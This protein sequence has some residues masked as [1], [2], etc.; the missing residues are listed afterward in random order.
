M[1]L[2]I[3]KSRFYGFGM[4]NIKKNIYV[5]VSLPYL[6]QASMIV[7][8]AKTFEKMSEFSLD[9]SLSLGDVFSFEIEGLG[10]KEFLFDFLCDG[11]KVEF[12]Y[13]TGFLKDSEGTVHY[14]FQKDVNPKG[15]ENDKPLCIPMDD[16]VIYST[17]VRG[18]SMG[19]KSIKKYKGTFKALALKADYFKSFSVNALELMPVYEFEGE[20]NYWGFGKANHFAINRKYSYSGNPSFEFK[21]MVQTLHSK[22]IEV[23]LILQFENNDT[24]YIC[25]VAKFYVENYHI[26]GF[27]FICSYTDYES[28]KNNPFLKDTKLFFENAKTSDFGRAKGRRKNIGTCSDEFLNNARRFLKGDED[29]VPFLSFA[30]R[31]NSSC[32]IPV[33][34]IS[35]FRSFTLYDTVSFNKK[36]NEA[37]NEE[38]LDGTNYNYSWNCGEEGEPLKKKTLALRLRQVRNAALITYLCQGIPRINGGDEVLNSN[39]GNN[40]PYCQDNEIGWITWNNKKYAKDYSLFLQNL[41]RFRNRHKILHQNKELMMFDYMSCKIPDVSFHS[42]KAFALDQ[43]PSSREF[44]VMY[45]GDYSKQYGKEKEDHIIVFYNM[46]WEERS[47]EIPEFKRKIDWFLLYSSDKTTDDSF[48][49]SKAVPVREKVYKLPGRTVTVLIGRD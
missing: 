26:D 2:K 48:D 34:F 5:G 47:F 39:F 38:N 27:R 45:C 15:F 7:Y 8:D 13:A 32:S 43:T 44:G 19:D 4:K 16:N 12:P 9:E 6:K 29:I 17:H 10:E 22:G 35:D 42:E 30:V 40:N 28:I 3:I 31:E 24:S 25:E 46:H 33:R 1:E 18:F 49:E 23:F 36:Y 21:E 37:N 11:K 41:L 20:N 14:Y